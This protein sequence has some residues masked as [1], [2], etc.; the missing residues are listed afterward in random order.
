MDD[1][2]QSRLADIEQRY[3]QLEERMA[4]PDIATDPKRLMEVG[5]ERSDLAPLVEAYRR[6]K[7]ANRQIV[8][9]EELRD[10]PDP[11]M[12]QMA[13]EE[14]EH[15]QERRERALEEIKLLLLPRDPNDDKSVVI[16]GR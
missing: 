13:R 8:E 12:A 6:Y 16:E 2:L 3:V 11:D 15:L 14:I 7:D 10:G 4:E 5:R 9:A 1:R